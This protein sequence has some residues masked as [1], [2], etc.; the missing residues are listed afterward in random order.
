MRTLLHRAGLPALLLAAL[1]VLAGCGG[2]G[3]GEPEAADNGE[4]DTAESNDDASV[5]ALTF[6]ATEF[7]FDPDQATIPADTPVEFVVDNQG[8]IEHDL[9]IDEAGVEIYV[10]PG[11]S[12]SAEVTLPAGDYVFYCSIPGHRDSGMEGTLTV[13]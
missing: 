6:V 9:A 4:Q 12:A 11:E 2:D 3:N 13:E 5:D 7:S 8:V 1:L 10:E